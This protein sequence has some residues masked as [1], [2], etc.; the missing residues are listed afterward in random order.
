M[1]D[2]TTNLFSDLSALFTRPVCEAET[3]KKKRTCLCVLCFL[4]SG[5]IFRTFRDEWPLEVTRESV[6]EQDGESHCKLYRYTACDTSKCSGRAIFIGGLWALCEEAGSSSRIYLHLLTY[7]LTPL[8]RFLPEKL[9]DFQLD[10]KFP[11]FYGPRRLITTFTTARHLS[12]SW[13]R[14]IQSM[15]PSNF[16][17]I[18]FN[19]ILPST[20]FRGFCNC[21]VKWLNF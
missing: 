1:L 15:P 16:S 7:L 14:S 8:S 10:K 19:I 5:R 12:L 17:N 6:T 21:F 13:A 3:K 9:K 2:T 18:H 11:A 20:G 4:P